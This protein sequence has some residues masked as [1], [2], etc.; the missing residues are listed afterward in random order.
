[1]LRTSTRLQLSTASGRNSGSPPAA[2]VTNFS[3]RMSDPD[4]VTLEKALADALKLSLTLVPAEERVGF[5][6]QCLVA[7]HNSAAQHEGPR[8]PSPAA[9]ST[10]CDNAG[11]SVRLDSNAWKA[12]IPQLSKELSRAVNAVRGQ[13]GWPLLAV[14]RQLIAQSSATAGTNDAAA[15]METNSRAADS[16]STAPGVAPADDK[17]KAKPAP[18]KVDVMDAPRGGYGSLGG[19]TAKKAGYGNLGKAKG[20]D[21]TFA[22]LEKRAAKARP[23]TLP[24]SAL[25]RLDMDDVEE[26]AQ[27]ARAA[28]SSWSLTGGT[29]EASFRK[30]RR[31]DREAAATSQSSV[32]YAS[33]LSLSGWSDLDAEELDLGAN[34]DMSRGS[35]SDRDEASTSASA[36][37]SVLEGAGIV[38]D[39]GAGSFTRKSVLSAA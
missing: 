11:A 27:S 35:L 20:G 10:S 30:K 7:A 32:G 23:Q 16:A 18:K 38:P 28:T 13:T 6:G 19:G 17:A 8:P 39:G 15:A 4:L 36:A 31:T 25:E 29:R 21:M 33:V 14:G 12:E 5:I 22:E 1:M 26:G 9:T 3:G 34:V 24:P 37:V 2:P